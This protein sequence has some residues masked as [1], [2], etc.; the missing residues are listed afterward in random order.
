MSGIL[1]FNA[2]CLSSFLATSSD[3]RVGCE[4]WHRSSVHQM[5]P[6]ALQETTLLG[7]WQGE[8]HG[9]SCLVPRGI[10]CHSQESILSMGQHNTTCLSFIVGKSGP[11]S[12]LAASATQCLLSVSLSKYGWA[13]RSLLEYWHLSQLPQHSVGWKPQLH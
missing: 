8:K 3:V 13:P 6:G 12:T 4:S 1:W 2:Q 10:G 5:G 11:P 9:G 7:L